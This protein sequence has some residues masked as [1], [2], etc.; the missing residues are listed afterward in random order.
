[1]KRFTLILFVAALCIYI[2]NCKPEL[3]SQIINNEKFENL[4]LE[5]VANSKLN[6]SVKPQN[7]TNNIPDIEYDNKYWNINYTD[8]SLLDNGFINKKYSDIIT[9]KEFGN[10]I[11]DKSLVNYKD[12]DNDNIEQ[13]NI[14]D[15]Y[16]YKSYY[17]NNK[18]YKLFGLGSNPYYNIY[19][20]I[21]ERE[22]NN[23]NEIHNNKLYE[24]I[25]VKKQDNTINVIQVFQPRDKI[26]IGEYINLSFGPSKLSY[27]LVS[28]I[29]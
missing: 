18:K 9:Y 5:L 14:N 16:P 10:D 17:Y 20:I 19:L 28:P 27:L 8:Y 13:Q 2:Y 3:I 29:N 15:E 12:N 1:M 6:L 7:S 23:E 4:D 11:I 25:L 24:Y 26:S 21:Y 22:V